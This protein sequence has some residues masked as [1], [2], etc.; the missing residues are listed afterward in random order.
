MSEDCCLHVCLSACLSDIQLSDD[1]YLTSAVL[2]LLRCLLSVAW[3]LV[4]SSVWYQ[5]FIVWGPLFA[6]CIF[7][8]RYV[9]YLP[10]AVFSWCLL[11]DAE[12]L[13]SA[14]LM[15]ITLCLLSAVCC[16]MSLIWCRMSTVFRPLFDVCC[17][18]VFW[19]ILSAICYLLS[20][21][22]YLTPDVCCLISFACCL[23]FMSV[24]WCLVSACLMTLMFTAYMPYVWC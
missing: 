19:Y 5:L 21:A 2:F 16:L 4:I 8:I 7:L 18:R 24:V 6:V 22:S 17:P 14:C 1:W 11:S 20:D 12:C 13:L 10:T 23:L 3:R 15:V 9:R